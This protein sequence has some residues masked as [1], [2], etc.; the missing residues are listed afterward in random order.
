MIFPNFLSGTIFFVCDRTS[1][2]GNKLKRQFIQRFALNR[3]YYH[4]SMVLPLVSLFIGWN[5]YLVFISV[6]RKCRKNNPKRFMGSG[7]EIDDT[8]Q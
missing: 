5:A 1:K 8:L 2:G 3:L 6:V 4:L 7:I